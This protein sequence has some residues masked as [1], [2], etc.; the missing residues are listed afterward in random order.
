MNIRKNIN[1]IIKKDLILLG[2]GHSNIEVLRK[3]GKNPIKNIRVTLINNAYTSTYSGMVPGYIQGSYDWS[4]INIDLIKLCNN[5][6]HRLIVATV[7]KI[8][9]K[10]K[11]NI[12]IQQTRNEL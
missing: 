6:N 2:A 5:C 12:L 8:D 3:L 1:N 11:I 7:S 10:K 9:I 4:D